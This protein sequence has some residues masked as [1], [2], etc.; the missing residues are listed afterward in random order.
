MQLG[1]PM[2][3]RSIVALFVAALFVLP[4]AAAEAAKPIALHPD[5]PHYFFFRGKP[6]ILIT[7]GEHYGA[8]LNGD[9]SYGKYLETLQAD[10][11]NLTRTFA[12]TYC[13]PDGAFKIARNTLAP[14]TGRFISPWA[15]SNEPGYHGGGN[16]FD[17]ARFDD[18]YFAR[19]KDFIAQ[20]G[21]R[22]VVVELVL[23][24]TMYKDDQW[25]LSPMNARN[26]INGVGAVK[27]ADV[28]TLDRSGGLL[29]FQ[30]ALVKKI[31]TEVKDYDNLYYEICN[32]PY[33][34]G[35]AMDW[36]HRIAE[37]IHETE[38]G[39]PSRHLIAQNIANNKKKVDKP[40]PA[41]SILNYHY[42]QPA[43]VSENY[44]LNLAIVDD[45][46]GFKKT[47]DEPYLAEAWEFFLSGGSGYSGLD[48]SFTVGHENGTFKYPPTQPGGGGPTLRAKLRV[49]RQ[50]L[51]GFDFVKLK[52]DNAAKG[53]RVLAEPGR[54]Y[55]V[56]RTADTAELN[57]SQGTYRAE[58]I[59]IDT[60][61]VAKNETINHSGGT[62]RLAFDKSRA[63]RLK[64][65]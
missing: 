20:A 10:G 46:T 41:V 36:Q 27:F 53:A 50:F 22:G 56:Y 43:A 23:F 39:F 11:M 14:A 54:Q 58:W 13:E 42:S 65:Q 15:R 49:L 4:L 34:A 16:K 7:S 21:K 17:L 44:G 37:V 26:N 29:P 5:N 48:Y 52:P 18:A 6:T 30:E 32:E 40:H 47:D 1:Q 19:L 64:A 38:K 57:V 25:N 61:R 31:V 2:L 8:V 24:C 62:L 35:V 63:V 51:E 60:G 28:L 55:A 59:D 9:F 33:F 3:V 12:G 45:E